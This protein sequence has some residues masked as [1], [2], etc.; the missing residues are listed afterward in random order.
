MREA[1]VRPLVFSRPSPRQGAWAG[2]CPI[3]NPQTHNKTHKM[4]RQQYDPDRIGKERDAYISKLREAV[5]LTDPSDVGTAAQHAKMDL[6]MTPEQR[7][8]SEAAT[9][10][11]SQRVML[12]DDVLCSMTET[13]RTAH[14]L[15][16]G[17]SGALL[18]AAIE[19]G[20]GEGTEVGAAAIAEMLHGIV[21][22]AGGLQ[23]HP[24]PTSCASRRVRRR[25]AALDRLPDVAKLGVVTCAKLP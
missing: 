2:T 4:P 24:A 10:S 5:G 9:W 13:E 18:G 19:Q 25:A 3:V 1:A 16:L 22:V 14:C 21:K 8:H 7:A 20:Q 6:L 11:R 23:A 15:L 12:G 17:A